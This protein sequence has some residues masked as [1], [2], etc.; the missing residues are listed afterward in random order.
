MLQRFSVVRRGEWRSGTEAHL[1]GRVQ[2]FRKRHL[3]NGVRHCQKASVVESTVGGSQ[4]R[5]SAV[6]WN[7]RRPELRQNWHRQFGAN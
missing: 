1:Q 4:L 5:R 6:A 7:H 2:N 3:S